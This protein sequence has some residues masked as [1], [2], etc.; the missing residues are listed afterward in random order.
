MSGRRELCADESGGQRR[1]SNESRCV[2]VRERHRLRY[3]RLD[4]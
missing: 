4:R 1:R 3:M 2:R